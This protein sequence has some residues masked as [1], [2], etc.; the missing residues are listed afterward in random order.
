M[1]TSLHIRSLAASFFGMKMALLPRKS[2]LSGIPEQQSLPQTRSKRFMSFESL[3]RDVDEATSCQS[4][5]RS[6]RKKNA[7]CLLN[8]WVAISQ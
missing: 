4:G 8:P 3:E 7:R 2:N 5:V 1:G 6:A